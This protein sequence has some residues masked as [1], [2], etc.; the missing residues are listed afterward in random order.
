LEALTV[1]LLPLPVNV[2]ANLLRM[3]TVVAWIC[4]SSSG[5]GDPDDGVDGDGETGSIGEF[6][7][8]SSHVQRIICG[9]SA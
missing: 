9:W 7:V 2:L 1:V 4:S 8:V 5:G 3:E 6:M